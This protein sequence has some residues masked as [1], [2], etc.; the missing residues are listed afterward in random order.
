[1]T[2]NIYNIQWD[3]TNYNPETDE[4]LPTKCEYEVDDSFGLQYIPNLL[5]DCEGVPCIKCQFDT[6]D[7]NA[8]VYNG[9]DNFTLYLSVENSKSQ[10]RKK[11]KNRYGI[12]KYIPS[13]N[14]E[15]AFN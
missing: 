15:L 2:L 3:L 10:W 13:L 5:Q 12:E 4:P 14:S 1:M 8:I 7:G 6:E 11:P 9:G